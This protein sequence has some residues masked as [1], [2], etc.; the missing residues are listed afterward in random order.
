MHR[1]ATEERRIAVREDSLIDIFAEHLISRRISLTPEAIANAFTS[2]FSM[3]KL[4]TRHNEIETFGNTIG[5][6]IEYSVFPENMRGAHYSL[7]E[8]GITILLDESGYAGKL[9]T[10]YHEIYE[11]ICELINKP[12]LKTEYRA[13]L[14]AAS[15]IMPEDYFFEYVIRRN[16]MLCEIKEYNPEIATDSILLRINYFLKK[17]GVLHAAF[18]LKKSTVYRYASVEDFSYLAGYQHC[19]ST[20][21]LRTYNNS[22]FARDIISECCRKILNTPDDE[23]SLIRFPR[24]GCIVLAEPILFT[25]SREIKEIAIQVIND[26]AYDNMR[27][28]IGGKRECSH[29]CKSVV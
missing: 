17:R 23:L 9:H 15:V 25:W 26:D 18:L 19:L 27:D 21:D 22:A 6:G 8:K 14:F 5:V 3:Y 28:L 13:N 29:I 7:A 12:K 20:L 1:A 2:F 10:L 24:P 11:I 4:P 16:L